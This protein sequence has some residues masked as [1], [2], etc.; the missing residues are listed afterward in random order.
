[1]HDPIQ[2]AAADV[3]RALGTTFDELTDIADILDD[4]LRADRSE[5]EILLLALGEL[6]RREPE[7][8][9]LIGAAEAAEILGIS[10]SRLLLL[11]EKK[12]DFPPQRYPHLAA[13]KLWRRQDIIAFNRTW[14]RRVGRPPKRS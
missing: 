11:A 5:G 6:T 7:R 4:H 1:M 2:Q 13:A 3:A 14:D 8:H 10:R 12:P 9:D